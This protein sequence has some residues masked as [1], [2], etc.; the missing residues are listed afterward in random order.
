[1]PLYAL[2]IS[3]GTAE[4][5]TLRISDPGTFG[6][7]VRFSCTG[8][9]Q[10]FPKVSLLSLSDANV[11][12]PGGKGEAKFVAKCASCKALSSVGVQNVSAGIVG[13]EGSEDAVKLEC[14]GC[15]PIEFHAGE[16]FKVCS[17]LSA[18]EWSASFLQEAEFCEFDE[19][20]G[21]S[22]ECSGVGGTWRKV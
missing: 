12:V 19:E 3:I 1:M 20:A 16:G 5:C 6:I 15:E 14:R 2:T 8:C 21:L 4:N 13:G 11:E 9:R 10:G 7:R 17:T 18:A 22:I